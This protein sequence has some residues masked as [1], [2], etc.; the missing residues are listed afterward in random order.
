MFLF[1][2]SHLPFSPLVHIYPLH[3]DQTVSFKSQWLPLLFIVLL[4]SY[5]MYLFSFHV[6]LRFSF[7]IH[8]NSH[9]GLL[10]SAFPAI[11]FSL[12]LILLNRL[13]GWADATQ[14]SQTFVAQKSSPHSSSPKPILTCINNLHIKSSL[15]NPF[16]YFMFQFVLISHFLFYSTDLNSLS[17]F[18]GFQP[19]RSQWEHKAGLLKL[20]EQIP[21]SLWHWIIFILLLHLPKY[22]LWKLPV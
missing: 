6:T 14:L 20:C 11:C 18:S 12:C 1:I 13:L 2:L 3:S 10:C 8:T 9:T 21:L 19:P 5:S 17:T 4:H 7:L 16:T 22:I 15:S